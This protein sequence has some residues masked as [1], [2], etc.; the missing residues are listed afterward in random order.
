[1]TFSYVYIKKDMSDMG[2]SGGLVQA[3][4]KFLLSPEGQASCPEFGFVGVPAGVITKALAW[5]DGVTLD[6]AVTPW[7]FELA[8]TTQKYEGQADHYFSGKRN[9][10]ASTEIESLKKSVAL[11]AATVAAE[12]AEDEADSK[13][14]GSEGSE[15]GDDDDSGSS[16]ALAAAA[17]AISV[18]GNVVAV[19][20]FI[21][22][23][24]RIGALE[25]KL[26]YEDSGDDTSSRA[27]RFTFILFLAPPCWIAMFC[28][29]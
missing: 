3:L 2:E 15:G 27:G 20:L 14:S 7:E 17:L 29:R 4:V 10:Y 12:H 6:A 5:I 24:S 19:V 11:L 28:T 25:K 21:R 1:M 16:D 22:I 18:I 9:S 13:S 8:S 26:V 23:F